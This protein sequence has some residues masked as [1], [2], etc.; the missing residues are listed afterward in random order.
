MWVLFMEALL[1]ELSSK[2]AN[3][4]ALSTS[5]EQENYLRTIRGEDG[6]PTDRTLATPF[7]CEAIPVV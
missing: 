5:A 4:F 1:S 7:G 6:C 2:G 3:A